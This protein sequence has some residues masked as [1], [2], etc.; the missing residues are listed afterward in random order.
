MAT[1]GVIGP[2]YKYDNL[3]PGQAIWVDL[4]EH[5]GYKECA[6]S[7]TATPHKGATGPGTHVLRVSDV[8]ITAIETRIEGS[9]YTGA[10]YFAG[11]H[12]T[13]VGETTIREWSWLV[14]VIVP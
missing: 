1:V 6:L 8:S 9:E 14:G 10:R 7:V 4:G 11:C 2:K 3:A 12:V 5:E 13:N